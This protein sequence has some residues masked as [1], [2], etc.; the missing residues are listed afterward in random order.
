MKLSLEIPDSQAEQLRDT[1]ERLGVAVESLAQ[2]AL[3]DLAGQCAADFQAVSARVL[4][5]NEEL[6]RRLA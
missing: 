6:Y 5:R 2:A 1:A 4:K 3:S